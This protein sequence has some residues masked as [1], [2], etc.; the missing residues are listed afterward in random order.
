M[1]APTPLDAGHY[2]AGMTRNLITITLSAV[3]LAIAG[4]AAGI[5]FTR[6]ADSGPASTPASTSAPAKPAP[7]ASAD[8]YEVYLKLAPHG[9]PNLS[10]EDAQARAYLGCGR[11]WSPGTVDAAL[12]KAYAEL[13]K[14][15]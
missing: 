14:G 7:T 13:C 8:P 3:A 4:A 15:R 12:A 6:P 10:R 2:G 5:Y 9:A 1:T 11:S